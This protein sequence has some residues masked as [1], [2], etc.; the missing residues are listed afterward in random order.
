MDFFGMGKNG[1][2]V[3]YNGTD[4]IT[5]FPNTVSVFNLFVVDGSVFV[6]CVDL[7]NNVNFII[8][9]KLK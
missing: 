9:G 7:E 4:I 2:I 3:H 8:H 5:L 6:V 1:D